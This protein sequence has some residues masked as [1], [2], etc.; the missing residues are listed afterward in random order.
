M[1]WMILNRLADADPQF[2]HS[3]NLLHTYVGENENFARYWARKAATLAHELMDR[4]DDLDVLEREKYDE[5][6]PE[7]VY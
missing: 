1:N 2:Q 7:E 4:A 5:I 3:I 6:F